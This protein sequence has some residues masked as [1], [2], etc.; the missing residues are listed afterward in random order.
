MSVRRF[1]NSRARATDGERFA[2]KVGASGYRGVSFH[3]PSGMWRAIVYAGGPRSFPDRHP[4]AEHHDHTRLRS[5]HNAHRADNRPLHGLANNWVAHGPVVGRASSRAEH[6]DNRRQAVD[7]SRRSRCARA[8]LAHRHPHHAASNE[9]HLA[10]DGR[11]RSL[12]RGIWPTA[13]GVGRPRFMVRPKSPGMATGW[14][15]PSPARPSPSR[16]RGAVRLSLATVA[17]RPPCV[18]RPEG[19]VRGGGNVSPRR[20]RSA[21]SL[22][23]LVEPVSAPERGWNR[24]PVCSKVRG[25]APSPTILRVTNACSSCSR[26]TSRNPVL[27]DRARLSAS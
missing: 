14:V 4:S 10:R 17:P 21:R 3:G 6:P 9:P 25:P 13:R 23:P 7:S 22:R 19:R 8:R 5:P 27:V 2:A 11:Y 15:W 26:S 20:P 16:P 18:S 24:R 12:G 1:T